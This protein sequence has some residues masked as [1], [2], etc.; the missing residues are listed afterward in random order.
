[1]STDS[2]QIKGINLNSDLFANTITS[3]LNQYPTEEIIETGT[4]DGLGSTSI[5]AKTGIDIVSI[6]SC[7]DH[8]N[9]A[10]ENLKNFSNVKLLLGSSL[11]YEE[12][13]N[14]ILND[15]IYNSEMVISKTLPIDGGEFSRNFYLSEVKG[16]KEQKPEIDNLLFD[17]IDNTKKQLVFLDS[18]GGVGYL[19]FL[20]FMSLEPEKL[21]TKILVLDDISHIKH[22][23]S[24]VYLKHN[25]YNVEISADRR[26]AYCIF[27]PYN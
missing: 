26:F 7:E 15:E 10:K 16:F 18:A 5:F 24:V 21:I 13:E 2:N 19:E 25:F 23:R 22:Y 17:L 1:M 27:R 20:K 4:F 3:L 8:Y 6:E 14:F 11:K 12:M 9:L